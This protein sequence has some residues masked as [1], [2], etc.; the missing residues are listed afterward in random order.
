MSVLPD[1]YKVPQKSGNYMKFQD[2]ENKFRILSEAVLG[3]EGW[4]DNADGSRKPVRHKLDEPFDPSEIDPQTIKHFWAVVVWNY[5][6]EKVQILE[7]TQRGIQKSLSALERSK[8][9]GDLLGYDILVTK[10]G[11]KLDTEYQVNPVPPKALS[12]KVE[13]A[14]A[15]QE[16]DLAK[17][18][19]GEDPFALE[20]PNLG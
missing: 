18:F 2:G 12:K 16:I 13:E 15:N 10:S 20:V 9:W 4:I 1:N 3:W 17:L 19:T 14:F 6:E 8:D 7:I 5:A 11:Q